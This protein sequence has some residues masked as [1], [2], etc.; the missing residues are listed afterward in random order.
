MDLNVIDY[1]IGSYLKK[2]N[3]AKAGK[4]VEKVRIQDSE[5]F[6]RSISENVCKN[7]GIGPLWVSADPPMNKKSKLA[8]KVSGHLNLQRTVSV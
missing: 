2:I 8:E 3:L 5:G 4:Q 7:K 1:H 6:H